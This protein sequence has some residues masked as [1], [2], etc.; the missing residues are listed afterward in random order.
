MLALLAGKKVFDVARIA[1]GHC[2]E[3]PQRHNSG[4]QR[5][6]QIARDSRPALLATVF[7][8]SQLFIG[9][10]EKVVDDEPE[11]KAT[12]GGEHDFVK[13]HLA[14]PLA[15]FNRELAHFGACSV[16]ENI[17]YGC[18]NFSEHIL[19]RRANFIHHCV[20]AFLVLK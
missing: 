14:S 13:E 17:Q 19:Y 7:R 2:K 6:E 15:S 4:D 1:V 12:S 3:R 10:Q 20:F 11:V 5:E 16:A 9:V 18:E 8:P